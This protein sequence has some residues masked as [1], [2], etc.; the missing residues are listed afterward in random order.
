M[1]SLLEIGTEE[2]PAKFMP[3]AL[4]QLKEL[5]EKNLL[6]QGLIT[7]NKNLWYT[8]APGPLYRGS[9]GGTAGF[10]GEVK[11]PSAK[12]A[13]DDQGNPSKAAG[14]C[15]GQGVDVKELTVKETDAGTYVFAL[16]K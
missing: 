11:G 7:G 12:V 4:E 3:P 10:G 2:I 6:K 13:F 8:T 15:P 5:A 1:G 16:K 14:F 9:A